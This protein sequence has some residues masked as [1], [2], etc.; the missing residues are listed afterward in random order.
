[1]AGME[2]DLHRVKGIGAKWTAALEK[3]GVDSVK[4][5]SNRNADSLAQMV[6]E[7]K[8]AAGSLSAKRA[9]DWISH[10]KR[11]ESHS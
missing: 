6:K 8:G 1:M 10:A 2:N 11:L 4:E 5:L 3:I 7:R 9:Q